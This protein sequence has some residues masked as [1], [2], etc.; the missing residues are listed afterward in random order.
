V[1]LPN[2]IIV[3]RRYYYIFL[4]TQYQGY[5]KGVTDAKSVQPTTPP[6]GT[7]ISPDDVDCDSSID[8]QASNQ[9]YCSGYQH[10]YADT[11]NNELVGK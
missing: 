9:D 7:M 10:G 4:I 8:P 1:Y 5:A 11:Y 3:Q 2:Y 6:T